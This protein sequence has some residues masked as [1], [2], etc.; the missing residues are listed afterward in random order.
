[1]PGMAYV[2]ATLAT[3]MIARHDWHALTSAPASRLHWAWRGGEAVMLWREARPNPTK[4]SRCIVASCKLCVVQILH[5]R[6]LTDQKACMAGFVRFGGFL[7][8]RRILSRVE[9][10]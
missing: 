4:L 7:R 3:E 1:M 2:D 8:N 9:L 6:C 10:R 5:D